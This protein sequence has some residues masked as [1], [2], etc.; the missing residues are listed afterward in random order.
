MWLLACNYH[1]HNL[2]KSE[3]RDESHFPNTITAHIIRV[4][5][6]LQSLNTYMPSLQANLEEV[7]KISIKDVTKLECY[8]TCL[9]ENLLICNLLAIPFA[10]III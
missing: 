5:G 1:A 6:Y 10:S 7:D 8:Q 9:T 2:T 3:S 4:L